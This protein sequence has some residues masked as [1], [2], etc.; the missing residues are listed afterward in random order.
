MTERNQLILSLRPEIPGLTGTESSPEEIFQNQTLRPILKFQNELLLQVFSH[1][2][3]QHKNAFFLLPEK[4]K[5]A[6]IQEIFQKDHKF[7]LFLKGLITGLFS[8]E[9]YLFYAENTASVNKR[10]V[11]LLMERIRS[12]KEILIQKTV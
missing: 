4:K 7:T 2:F 10:I 1:Y 9:E 12:Q 6:Y 5:G 3:A 8:T 11:L